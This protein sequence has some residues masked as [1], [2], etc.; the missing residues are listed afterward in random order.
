MYRHGDVLIA[1]AKKIPKGAK[2]RPDRILAKGEITGHSH[3][4][5]TE[6]VA[7]LF[8]SG[9]DVFVHVA[10]SPARVVHEEHDT[11][12]LQPGYYRVWRQREYTPEEIRV[13]RD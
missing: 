6:G 12:T 13:V 1:P 4:V 3:R 2:R 8:D 9:D 11:V 5:E 10:E 7:V